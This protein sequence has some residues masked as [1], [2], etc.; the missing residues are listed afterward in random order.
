M[1][2]PST[3]VMRTWSRA[4]RPEA[5]PLRLPLAAVAKQPD[6]VVVDLCASGGD[7]EPSVPFAEGFGSQRFDVHARPCHLDL[8]PVPVR[9]DREAASG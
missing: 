4:H 6:K 3:F 7:H 9:R 8:A 1:A 5:L 2:R